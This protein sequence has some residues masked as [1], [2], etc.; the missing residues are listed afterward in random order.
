LD[1]KIYQ[2]FH[3]PF[4]AIYSCDW[5]SPIG[6]SG[7]I[8]QNKLT[9]NEGE[10]ISNKNKYYC[11]LTTIYYAWKNCKNNYIGFYHYRRYLSFKKLSYSHI[12]ISD[13]K[14]I[15]QYIKLDLID[16][17]Q[18][19]C[20]D[21]LLNVYDVIVPKNLPSLPNIEEQYC[22][23][24]NSAV[25]FKFIDVLKNYYKI[26]EDSVR[27]FKE[28]KRN[29]YWN[30]FVMKRKYFDLYCTDLFNIIDKVYDELGHVSN[31]DKRRYNENRYPGYLAER[32][33]G[34]WLQ[35]NDINYFETD[36]ISIL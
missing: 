3:K 5:L 7:Y 1:L 20:L 18:K 27:Y 17:D 29:F 10:N 12:E 6:V 33:L 21:Y 2:T 26:N 32:F 14:L 35:L 4:P 36:A 9:D 13:N 19:L 30:M 15:E 8:P 25:W 23:Y 11:E 22:R 31:N 24:H 34:Y 16:S 28:N